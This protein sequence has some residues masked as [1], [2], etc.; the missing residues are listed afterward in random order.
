MVQCSDA[1][2]W[3]LTKNNTSFMRKV[4]G[5]TKRSG[6]VRFS[7]EKGNVKNISSYKYSGLANSKTVDVSATDDNRA[8]LSTKSSKASTQPSKGQPV[9]PLNKS[10]RRVE[11]TITSQVADNNYRP[12]LKADALARYSAIYAGNRVAKGVK[13][14]VPVKKGRGKAE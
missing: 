13:K 1:L 12:D 11:K 3:E 6:T 9:T 14:S 5:K 10:F 7:V 2:V 4:N 8:A